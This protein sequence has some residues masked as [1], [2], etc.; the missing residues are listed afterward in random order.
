MEGLLIAAPFADGLAA[1]IT[2]MKFRL[3]IMSRGKNMKESKFHKSV[4]STR[5]IQLE[6]NKAGDD[7]SRFVFNSFCLYSSSG[8][9][10]SAVT[11]KNRF[12][13]RKFTRMA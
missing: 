7:C 8:K 6:H 5:L 11:L 4:I 1:A 10:L 3:D 13:K 12:E 2:W 9:S